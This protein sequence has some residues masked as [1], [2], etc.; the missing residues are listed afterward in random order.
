MQYSV[1]VNN[2]RLDATEAV[3]GAAPVIKI[4][5]GSPPVDCATA[6]SGTHIATGTLPSDS[7]VAASNASKSKNGVWAI[8]GLAAAGAS[9]LMGYYRIYDSTGTTCHEQG[10]ITLTGVGGGT[11]IEFDTPYIAYGEIAEI[12]VY[13]KNSGNT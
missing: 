5:T 3:I 4:F 11:G 2:A 6:D 12:S 1:A 8:V 10:P 13:T 7:M 9:T